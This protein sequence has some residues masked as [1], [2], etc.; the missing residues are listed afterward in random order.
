MVENI[1]IIMPNSLLYSFYGKADFLKKYLFRC[2]ES[3]L[4][5]SRALCG[6]RGASVQLWLVDSVTLWHV[7]SWFPG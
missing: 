7:G 6:G 2:V 1:Y 4:Q 3:W 5:R